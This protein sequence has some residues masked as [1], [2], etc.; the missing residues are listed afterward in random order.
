MLE[1]KAKNQKRQLVVFNTVDNP[2]LDN[3]DSDDLDREEGNRNNSAMIHQ[4]NLKLSKK[5]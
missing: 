5:A 3:K 1:K 2:G 4:G